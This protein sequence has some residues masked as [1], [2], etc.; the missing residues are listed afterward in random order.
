MN[1]TP[2]SVK[3]YAFNLTVSLEIKVSLEKM[4]ILPKYWGKKIYKGLWEEM[5]ISPK[6]SKKIWISSN[7]CRKK[8]IITTR[9]GFLPL[10][11]PS[12]VIFLKKY[13]VFHRITPWR[14]YDLLLPYSKLLLRKPCQIIWIIHFLITF[15]VFK[16]KE[17]NY[18]WFQ[19][20]IFPLKKNLSYIHHF[21]EFD[22][23][24][25]LIEKWNFLYF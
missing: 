15:T 7:V 9:R 6:D 14:H 17:I 2:Q 8:G 10:L 13:C 22:Y 3:H 12:T 23:F 20:I 19:E 5:R 24:T 16:F 4:Q 1:L 11:Y 21:L 25:L 18:N